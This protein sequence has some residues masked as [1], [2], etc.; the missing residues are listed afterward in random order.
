MAF[1]FPEGCLRT[2]NIVREMEVPF[3]VAA[4]L[5]CGA[6][7]PACSRLLAGLTSVE[8][9]RKPAGKPAAARIGCP[10]TGAEAPLNHFAARRQGSKKHLCNTI[11]RLYFGVGPRKFAQT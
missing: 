11:H 6:G 1:P 8:K 4:M 9:N 2:T 5:L 3:L 10:T 7:N